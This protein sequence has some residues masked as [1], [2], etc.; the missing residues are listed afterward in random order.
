MFTKY[1]KFPIKINKELQI[2]QI[3]LGNSQPVTARVAYLVKIS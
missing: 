2:K 1:H 3:R